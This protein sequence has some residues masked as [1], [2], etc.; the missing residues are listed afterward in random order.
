VGPEDGE[1]ESAVVVV[2]GSMAGDLGVSEAASFLSLTVEI[3]FVDSVFSSPSSFVVSDL[4]IGVSLLES[5]GVSEGE[6]TSMLDSI[7]ESSLFIS[8]AGSRIAVSTVSP[9]S[10]P[11]SMSASSFTVSALEAF[12]ITVP[13]TELSF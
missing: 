5:A 11:P 13:S 12:S 6:S 9:V 4:G 1:T 2:V 7:A 3:V 8:V 10:L